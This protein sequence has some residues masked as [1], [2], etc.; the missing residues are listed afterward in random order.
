[1]NRSMVTSY[2]SRE[3]SVPASFLRGAPTTPVSITRVNFPK[4]PLSA[5]GASYAVV[6]DNVLSP[7][8][9]AQMLQYCEQ[10]SLTYDTGKPWAT[11]LVNVGAGREVLATDYRNSE[12]II[13]DSQDLMDRLWQRCLRADGLAEDLSVLDGR[14]KMQESAMGGAARKTKWRTAPET[15]KVSRL[16]DRMR[17]LRYEPG[18]FFRE[19]CDGHYT[20]PPTKEKSWFTLQLYLSDSIEAVRPGAEPFVCHEPESASSSSW[21]DSINPFSGKGQDTNAAESSEGPVY[22][23]DGTEATLSGGATTFFTDDMRASI[24]V[25]PRAGRVLIFQQR[26]LLHSGGDVNAG[27]KYTMRTDLMYSQVLAKE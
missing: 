22:G 15:W 25:F 12:R 26:G 10:S 23:L 4:T 3:V 1:M 20:H 14:N 27:V 21:L 9:C 19:H 2:S 24:D 6:L 7:A 17:F 18:M 8:E 5:R 13:W 11:A 16:N